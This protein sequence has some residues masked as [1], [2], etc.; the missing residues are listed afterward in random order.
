MEQGHEVVLRGSSSVIRPRLGRPGN[1]VAGA[2]HEWRD[3]LL[4]EIW[5][6]MDWLSKED[7]GEFLKGRT[8]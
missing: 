3:F 8:Q 7:C 4:H 2:H 5:R 1:I 6:L